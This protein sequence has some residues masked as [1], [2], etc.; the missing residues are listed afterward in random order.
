[1]PNPNR[2]RDSTQIELPCRSLEGI[3]D[4]LEAEHTV[5]VVQPEGQQCRIIGSPIE[6]KAASNF[7]SRHGVTLP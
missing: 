6:I 2:L 1:M 3:Q 4:D 5:T 7:L